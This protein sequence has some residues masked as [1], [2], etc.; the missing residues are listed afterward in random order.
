MKTIKIYTTPYVFFCV[1][2]F[3]RR[4]LSDKKIQRRG[5]YGIIN[6]KGCLEEQRSD[7]AKGNKPIDKA[8]ST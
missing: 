7:K 6:M 3:E 8:V 1:E 4:V 2:V 5:G